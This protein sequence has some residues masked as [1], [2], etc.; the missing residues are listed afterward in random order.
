L[1]AGHVTAGNMP[2]SLCRALI[3]CSAVQALDPAKY[4]LPE[5]YPY[6][7]AAKFFQEPEVTPA[8]QL[9]PLKWTAPDEEALVAYLVG[10]C[11][12]E[13]GVLGASRS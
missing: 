11:C 7:E 13:Q 10:R 2:V 12:A 3:A 6:K 8:D 5:P 1:R 4:P 9:P